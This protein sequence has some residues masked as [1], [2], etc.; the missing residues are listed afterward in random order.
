MF[1]QT[2]ILKLRDIHIYLQ[3]LFSYMLNE[4]IFNYLT[5]NQSTKRRLA[6]F[7]LFSSALDLVL[8][9]QC[10]PCTHPWKVWIEL[11]KYIKQCTLSSSFKKVMLENLLGIY[12]SS[13]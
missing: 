4:N 5:H 10:Q 8:I 1:Y 9:I 13:Q 12:V 11:P 6:N 3:E 2:K 7:A